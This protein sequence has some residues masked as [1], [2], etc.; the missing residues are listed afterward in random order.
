[1]SSNTG[2]T[3]EGSIVFIGETEKISETFSKRTLVLSDKSSQYPQEICFE[4]HKSNCDLL[5]SYSNTDEVKV[6]YN[7]NGKLWK[8]NKWFNSLIVWK[9]EGVK[10][11]ENKF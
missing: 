11:S 8:D 10:V 4:L 2:L 1:M 6:S 3:Y 7:L 9:I 5:N